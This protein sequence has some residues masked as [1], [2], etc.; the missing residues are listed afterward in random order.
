MPELTN[1]PAL[2]VALGLA[3]LY[4]VLST[5]CSSISELIASIFRMRARNLEVGIRTLLGSKQA[6]DDF[7]ANWRIESLRTPKWF[8]DFRGEERGKGSRKPSYIPARSFALAV[9]DTFAPAAAAQA[10][11]RTPGQKDAVDLLEEVRASAA[12]IDERIGGKELT[13]VVAG[14][15]ADVDAFRKH[16]EDAFNEVMDRATGWYKRK[17]QVILF[18]I[19]LAV[20]GGLNADTFNVAD[21]L[22]RDDALRAAVVAQAEKAVRD[23]TQDPEQA[24]TAKAVEE[25]IKQARATALP[26]GWNG[27]NVPEG[28]TL[29]VVL[30]KAAGLLVTT[31]ALML[32]APFWFD[33]LGRFARIRGT[34]N[35]IGT[36]KDDET[37]PS[38]R[39][40][41][42]RYG[43]PAGGA[44]APPVAET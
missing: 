25:Q 20:S 27:E 18:V 24:G 7:Y 6:A 35:R 34:G 43:I 19:A 31:F 3:F 5:I 4:F 1:L 42:P 36:P 32:G 22:A 38:D 26:L 15:R 8:P 21:R 30:L 40:E 41:P 10:E 12:R 11:K 17:I 29:G 39:D 23:G 16:L 2:D 44:P 13:Q 28:S 33:L 37:A 9:L 14:A